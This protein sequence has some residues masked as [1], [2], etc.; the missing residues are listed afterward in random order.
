MNPTFPPVSRHAAWIGALLCAS[1]VIGFAAM[2]DGYLHAQHPLGLLGASGIPR[3]LAFNLLGFVLPGVLLAVT[4]VA[5]RARLP[6]T[7]RRSAGIGGWLLAWSALAF[8]AQGLLPLDPS[9][10]DGA[11]SRGHATAWTLWWIA[12][13][14][15]ALLLAAGLGR[16]AAWR[17]LAMLMAV[18]A[19]VVLLLAALPPV[20]VPGPIAQRIALGAWLLAY[21]VASR[22]R[23]SV[24]EDLR[25]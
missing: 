2:L 19:I 22:G 14:P 3:A 5:L 4:A 13:V 1:A 8:A 15:G 18:C 10:L 9:D 21:I 11:Q 7:A 17:M 23:G 12:F 25:S 6:D 24:T 20:L 16:V